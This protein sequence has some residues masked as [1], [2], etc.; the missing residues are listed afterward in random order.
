MVQKF[1]DANADGIIDARDLLVQQFPLTDGRAGMVIGGITNF[2][3][4]GDTDTVAGQ[5]TAPFNIP[6]GDFTQGVW[7]GNTCSNCRSSGGILRPS[8]KILTSP[9]FPWAQQITGTV[10]STGAAVTVPNAV[11]VFFAAPRGGQHGP[12]N[13]VA[14]TVADS[15][16]HFRDSNPAGNLCA[17]NFRS[18]YVSDFVASPVLTVGGGGTVATN[19]TLTG[20][21]AG[22]SGKVVDA[23]DPSIGLP[24]VFTPTST[25]AGLISATFTDTNGN[26]PVRVTSRRPWNLG[27]DDSRPAG[28]MVMSD[29]RTAPISS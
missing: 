23:R 16:G 27:G 20:A 29:T 10:V 2:N 1:L 25:S 8:S 13:P 19:L 12:G 26:F 11:V 15:S 7:S 18:N 14:G 9:I 3:V 6:N 22:I 28:F 5:I 4:P 17:R 24:G 21:T